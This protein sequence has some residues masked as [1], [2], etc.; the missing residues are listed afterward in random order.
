MKIRAQLLGII[1]LVAV[2][3][4][5]AFGAYGI[6]Q[7]AA[8]KI[9]SERKILDELTSALSAEQMYLDA[10]WYRTL[11]FTLTDYEPVVER[12]GKA[13]ESVSDLEFLS[14]KSETIKTAL[15][16]IAKMNTHM[17]ER[18]GGFYGAVENYLSAA[19]NSGGI[20]GQM[21]LTD[22]SLHRYMENKPGYPA[23]LEAAKDLSSNLQIMIQSCATAVSIVTDQ[24]G[25][26]EE[27]L[28][29]QRLKS[30]LLALLVGLVTGFLGLLAA[31]AVARRI[32]RRIA[33]LEK[34]GKEI[35]DGNL[36]VALSIPGKDEIASLGAIL[37][38]TRTRLA[39]SMSGIRDA[40]H[41]ADESRIG[42]DRA[43]E[44]SAESL[45]S[46]HSETEGIK[47]ASRRLADESELSTAAVSSIA[48]GL[49]NVAGMIQSQAAMVEE[50]TAAVTEMASSLKSLGGIMERNK[51]GAGELVTLAGAGAE[52]LEETNGYISGINAHV[53]TIQEMAN[54]IDGI[55][56]QTN[57]LAMNA[58]IEAA[59]AGEAG[60]GFSVVADEIR[61]LAEAAA[62]NSRSI[63][64]NLHEVVTSINGVTESSR[65]TSDSFAAIHDGV[66]GV[67]A[68]FDEILNAITELLEGGNQIMQAMVELNDFTVG[69]TGKTGEIQGQTANVSRSVAASGESAVKTATALAVM[70]GHLEDIESN[71]KAVSGSSAQ[72]RE[73]S[74]DLS[75]EIAKYRLG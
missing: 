45:G 28:A 66:T 47:S 43:V 48:G 15:E 14:T 13:L 65:R 63:K 36:S 27:E 62:V 50:S 55:A 18:R 75:G 25:V 42:L 67:S 41:K 10:F 4:G 26:I 64:T 37:E 38:A 35:G 30:I 23:F 2:A 29:A 34:A 53:E 32:S 11:Q 9:E 3:L 40:A 74:G 49:D 72:L 7:S 31:V 60:K 58:A 17:S 12:T 57:L 8:A 1:A 46:L 44:D 16:Q 73:I 51:T 24:N 33:I 54:L 56:S 5:L 61:K 19:E 21:R 59:H 20:R 68:S 71:F 39:E 69:V 70:E 52:R 6:F 22:F